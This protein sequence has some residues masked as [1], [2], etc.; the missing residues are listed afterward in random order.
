[1][2][3]YW[4]SMTGYCCGTCRYCVPTNDKIGRCRR[5]APTLDGYPIIYILD[6][7]CGNHKLGTNPLAQNYFKN[8]V[9]PIDK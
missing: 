2:K 7:F 9:T 4:D 1:M 6:D 3:N 8:L 5:N